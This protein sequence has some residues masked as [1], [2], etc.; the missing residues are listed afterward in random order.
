MFDFETSSQ[1]AGWLKELN[2]EHVPETEEYGIASFVYRRNKPF[3]PERLMNWIE[4]WPVE[5]VRAKG[6][7]WLATRNDISGLLSQ[8]GPSLTIQGAGKWIATYP[9]AE[10]KQILDEEPELLNRWDDTYGDRMTEVVMIGIDM[11]QQQIERALDACLLTK[12]EM[13]QDWSKF[14]DPLPSFHI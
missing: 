12:E 14:K 1:G 2:E 5:V 6:F 13:V 7:I 3:H 11:D 10:R 8:A 4:D 9:E